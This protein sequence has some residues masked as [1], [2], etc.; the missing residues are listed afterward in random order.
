MVTLATIRKRQGIEPPI[1]PR[2][3]EEY[4]EAKRLRRI[5]NVVNAREILRRE[6]LDWDELPSSHPDGIAFNVYLAELPYGRIGEPVPY[7]PEIGLWRTFGDFAVRYGCKNLVKYLK[8]LE[9]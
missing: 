9:I 6:G 1:T 3:H 8:G 2:Q 4:D 5:Q 7:W